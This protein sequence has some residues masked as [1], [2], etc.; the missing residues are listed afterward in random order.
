[1]KQ[2]LN[3]KTNYKTKLLKT[4][5]KYMNI[6][7]NANLFKCMITLEDT[8]KCTNEYLDQPH[9]QPTIPEF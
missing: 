7:I 6:Q 9:W 3:Y 5:F 2:Y 8:Y 1:M 4:T